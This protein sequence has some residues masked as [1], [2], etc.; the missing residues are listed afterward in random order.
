[1]ES[2]ISKDK[3]T[4]YVCGRPATC[5]HHI[6]GGVANRPKSDKRGFTVR[7]CD[8]CHR[9]IHKH[10]NEGVSLYLR[11]QCQKYYEEHYGTREDFINEFGKSRL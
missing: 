10:I 3:T 1:M 5:T 2:I 7:L 9:S 8:D 4:C 6:L 11:K